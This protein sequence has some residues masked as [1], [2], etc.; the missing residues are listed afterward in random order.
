MIFWPIFGEAWKAMGANRLRTFLTMLGMIIGVAAVI[1]MLAFGR[2][3]QESVN[4]SIA[5]MGT[6]LLMILSGSTTSGGLRMGM[7]STPTL[8]IED[9]RAIAELPS[10]ERASAVM[11]GTAQ[12]VQGGNN[13]SSL[14]YGV[15]PDYLEVRNWALASGNSFDE[16]ALRS[17]TQVALL[18]Q[19]VADNL[20]PDGENPLGKTIRIK[21]MPFLVIG[22]LEVKGQSMEGRNQDD[23]VVI[24]VTT[25][26]RRLFGTRFRGSV[27]YIMA[28]AVSAELAKEA[29]QEITQL[30]RQRHQLG[31]N[32][33]NRKPDDFTLRNLSELAQTAAVAARAFALLLG[34]IASISLLVGGIGIMNIMLVSVTERTRE[35]GIRLAIGARRRDIT[36]QFLLESI[37]ISLCGCLIGL[38]IGV[39][40][41]WLGQRLFDLP[42]LVTPSS[43]LLALSV[44]SSI[45][46]FFGLY[47]AR[48]A[49]RLNPIDALRQ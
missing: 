45:G 13:W 33:Q 23:A 28:Q 31:D 3:A 9:A 21:N 41:S 6:N 42:V 38:I 1:L 36:L 2:G 30:L 10:I 47:P 27:Q 35:I 48:R 12:L 34:A 19:T 25:A 17:A 22:L 7:G 46:I 20:F 44:A 29:E 5:D 37:L 14:V 49:A 18:G 43:V 4:K 40:G 8:T 11:S 16:A 39:G 24:P 26:Q 32:E 15:T